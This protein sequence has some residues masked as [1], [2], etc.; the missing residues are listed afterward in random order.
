[1]KALHDWGIFNHPLLCDIQNFSHRVADIFH[2]HTKSVLLPCFVVGICQE[3]LFKQILPTAQV[4][5]I[6]ILFW[7]YVINSSICSVNSAVAW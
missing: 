3:I 5:D 2:D 4:A 7:Y 6:Y 1:M